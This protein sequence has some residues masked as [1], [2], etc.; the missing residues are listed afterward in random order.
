MAPRAHPND[1]VLD[2]IE[3]A[4]TMPT[5]ERWKARRRLPTG[6]HVPHP[7]ITTRRVRHAAF[8]FERPLGLWVDGVAR[9]TVRS[10]VVAVEPDA[11]EI[12]V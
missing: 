3:V 8:A 11:V 9:G 4:A 2:V 12:Y 6:T 1:G 10:L 5:R 7:D